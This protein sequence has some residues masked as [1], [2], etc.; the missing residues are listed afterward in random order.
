MYV[1]REK[2]RARARKHNRIFVL[3]FGWFFAFLGLGLMCGGVW[4]AL[5]GVEFRKGADT[6]EAVILAMRG[7]TRESLGMPH[8]RY[9]VAGKTYEATLTSAS[10][11]MR[12]GMVIDVLYARDNPED[13]RLA[14]SDGFFS[15]VLLFMGLVFGGMGTLF[16]VVKKRHENR[17]DR[18]VAAGYH[19]QAE[20]TNIEL[21]DEQY[22]N[23]RHPIILSCRYVDPSGRVYLFRSG[24]VWYDS[25]EVV[26]GKKVRVYME[27]TRPSSYYVDVESVIG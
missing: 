24:S 16:L 18:L 10:G 7:K 11:D 22:A 1:D 3:V 13:V 2:A 12:P 6:T 17:I 4:M 15:G 21:D 8:V 27:R 25:H 14:G 26:P 23:G 5:E 9:H 19:V 20:V